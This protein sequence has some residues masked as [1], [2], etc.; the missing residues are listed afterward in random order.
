MKI[1]LFIDYGL[2]KLDKELKKIVD[3][4]PLPQCRIDMV[5]YI[6]K[7]GEFVDKYRNVYKL[8]NSFYSIEDVDISRP[9]R[10]TDYDGSEY[11]QYLDYVVIDEELNYCELKDD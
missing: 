4:Y 1:A 7:N 9:W 6:E 8:A 2:N 5:N 10:V 3:E 11:V